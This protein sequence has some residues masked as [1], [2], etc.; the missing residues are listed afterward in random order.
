MITDSQE[1][2]TRD[3]NN[4]IYG[5]RGEIGLSIDRI[6]ILDVIIWGSNDFTVLIF[7]SAVIGENVLIHKEINSSRKLVNRYILMST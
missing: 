5:I 4:K 2:Y 7:F 6:L 3:I 1:R